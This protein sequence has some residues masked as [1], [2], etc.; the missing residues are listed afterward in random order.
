MLVVLATHAGDRYLA[1]PLAEH[2]RALGGV[3]G[4]ELLIVAPN[5]TNL[6]G[7]EDV[8]RPAFARVHTHF[9]LETMKGWPFGANE[10]AYHIFSH[11]WENQSLPFYFLILEPDCVPVTPRWLDDLEFEYK[12]CGQNILGVSL[13]TIEIDTNRQVGVHTVGVAVY[14]KT[15]YQQCPLLRSVV[16]TTRTYQQQGGMPP[17]WD[18]YFGPYTARS[19]AQTRLIQHLPREF[20]RDESGMRWDLPLEDALSMVRKEAVL[21]HGC[22]HPDFIKRL[23]GEP[24]DPKTHKIGENGLYVD[25][26]AKIDAGYAFRH[27]TPDSAQKPTEENPTEVAFTGT[28][29]EIKLKKQYARAEVRRIKN[30]EEI[31]RDWGIEFPIDTPEFKRACVLFQDP[32]QWHE[33]KA[34]AKE[35]GLRVSTSWKKGQVMCE[36]V[37]AELGQRKLDWTK[38]VPEVKP[39]PPQEQVH[40]PP[41]LVIDPNVHF[42]TSRAPKTSPIGWTIIPPGPVSAPTPGFHPGSVTPP[43]IIS[44]ERKQQM[45]QLLAERGQHV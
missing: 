24:S 29:E 39:E 32:M 44:E 1:I 15:F 33:K 40:E 25:L 8:M 9:Y 43:T 35:L 3:S 41:D 17:P 10:A 38:A 19:T 26:P 23:K 16:A 31:R 36:I 7:I 2:I 22:K 34:Y 21:V 42:E 28:K 11:V 14:P 45:R 37:K 13:P 18:A 27:V 20:T 4:H 12:R 5:G 6:Q 30:L